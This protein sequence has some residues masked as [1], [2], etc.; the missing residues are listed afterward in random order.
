[1]KR[2]FQN[3]KNSQKIRVIIKDHNDHTFGVYTTIKDV[4]LGH[5]FVHTNHQCVAEETL[6]HLSQSRSA[7]PTVCGIVWVFSDCQVQVDLC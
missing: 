2:F 5:C 3:F 4:M 1:M 7:T 6:A